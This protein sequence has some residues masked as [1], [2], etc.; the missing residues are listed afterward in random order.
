MSF[1]SDR[2]AVL[3]F[4]RVTSM[5]ESAVLRYVKGYN[6]YSLGV[7]VCILRCAYVYACLHVCRLMC[8]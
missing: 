8:V 1:I 2:S 7:Y 5:D 6:C 3:Y 4:L